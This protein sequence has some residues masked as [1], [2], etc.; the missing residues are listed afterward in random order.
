MLNRIIADVAGVTYPVKFRYAEAR[1]SPPTLT[2]KFQIVLPPL[3]QQ[4]ANAPI[5]DGRYP[6]GIVHI[7]VFVF[8]PKLFVDEAGLMMPFTCTMF[9]IFLKR[10]IYPAVSL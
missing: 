5:V 7:T 3:P 8:E 4:A 9:P 6:L 1:T 2:S 10:G